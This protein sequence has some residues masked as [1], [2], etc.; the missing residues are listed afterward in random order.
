MRMKKRYLIQ[1][2]R[3]LLCLA[4]VFSVLGADLA[5]AMAVTQQEIDALKSDAGDLK[6]K[7][8]ALEAQLAALSD[9]KAEVMKRK[10]L[11]DQQ[12]SYTS[13]QIR[14]VEEQIATY[15]E[16]IH[17]TQ[18]ELTAA[19]EK[20]AAQYELFC[21]Q[22]RSMEESGNVDY[23]AVL[24][25]ARSISDLLGRLDIVNEIMDYNQRVIQDLKDLQA[26]V[27][28]KKASLETSKAESEAAK[29]ELVV[30]K[31]DLDA[32][33]TEANLLIQKIRDNESAYKSAVNDLEREEEEW[34]EW[35]EPPEDPMP[36]VPKTG[37]TFPLWFYVMAMCVSGLGL[38]ILGLV[39][40]RGRKYAENR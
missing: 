38:M 26:E 22:V 16:L 9:D 18:A 29:A 36:W 20:E 14:N 19:E 1:F 24:F 4:M 31:K 28:A 39:S 35:E 17:Q 21:K 15:T 25:R 11:L 5:P 30:V 23:W 40:R 33:R 32:R 7:R 27:A 10:N 3:M 8:K 34:E 6:N 37:D 2:C 12:I 13:S